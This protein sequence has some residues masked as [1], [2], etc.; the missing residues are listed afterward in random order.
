MTE[1]FGT[2]RFC[3]RECANSRTHSPETKTKISRGVNLHNI[4]KSNIYIKDDNESLEELLKPKEYFC[5]LC[6]KKLLKKNKSG[7]CKDCYSKAVPYSE[8]AKEKQRV[9]MTGRSRWNIHRNQPS[10]AEKFFEQVLINNNIPYKKEYQVKREDDYHCYYL[11]FLLPNSI[12]L[13]IDGSQHS[14]RADQDFIRDEYLKSKGYTIYRIKWNSIN[15]DKGSEEIRLKIS[16][17][18]DFY[19]SLATS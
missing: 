12:D 19:N 3:S 9:A 10:Y 4:I 14:Y 7:Y 2:G 5:K 16:K 11:D 13:E 18:L 6:G 1:K 8:S 17:F 15:S